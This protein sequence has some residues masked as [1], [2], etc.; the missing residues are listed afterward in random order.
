MKPRYVI[1]F[2][3]KKGDQSMPYFFYNL[4]NA[5]KES[6]KYKP[7]PKIYELKIQK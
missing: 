1:F 4:D 3:H 2:V 7:N 5:K 6:K